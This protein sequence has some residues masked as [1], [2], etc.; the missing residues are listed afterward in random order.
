M[1]KTNTPLFIVLQLCAPTST[2][3]HV[4]TPPPPSTPHC[5]VLSVSRLQYHITSYPNTQPRQNPRHPTLAPAPSSSSTRVLSDCSH[6]LQRCAPP[7]SPR[8]LS[9]SLSLSLSLSLSFSPRHTHTHT[10]DR[11]RTD[12]HLPSS[13]TVTRM[14]HPVS[15]SFRAS[16]LCVLP[17]DSLS[18]SL[19]LSFSTSTNTLFRG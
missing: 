11:F 15:T 6:A 5:L 18:L 19:S 12:C 4:H 13:M 10:Q 9:R 7:F 17:A 3:M 8:F 2:H 14:T 1:K 16:F